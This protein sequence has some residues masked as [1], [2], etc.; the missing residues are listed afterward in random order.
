MTRIYNKTEEKIKRKVLRSSMPRDEVILWSKL[1]GKKLGG[2][3]FR[4][5]YS[6][7]KFVIDFYCPELRLAVEVDGD[8]HY[9]EGAEISDRERQA[10]IEFFGITFLRFTNWEIYENLDGVLVK[11]ARHTDK[12]LASFNPSVSPLGK[13][14]IFTY[15]K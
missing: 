15:S 2:Y 12:L 8:S 7:G 4:H 9:V 6:V 3:K 5:Q 11:I 13:G 1:K 10:I 14:R